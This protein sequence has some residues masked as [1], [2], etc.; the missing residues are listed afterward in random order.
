MSSYRLGGVSRNTVSGSSF[1]LPEDGPDGAEEDCLA[2]R[3]RRLREGFLPLPPNG[4]PVVIV[5][6]VSGDGHGTGV[7]EKCKGVVR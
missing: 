2:L 4:A 3:V 1:F 6:D 5:V 7:G